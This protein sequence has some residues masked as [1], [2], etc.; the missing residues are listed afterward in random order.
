[1]PSMKIRNRN[2]AKNHRYELV[3]QANASGFEIDYYFRY[4]TG[5]QSCAKC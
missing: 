1:M 2:H 5:G 4:G 3:E